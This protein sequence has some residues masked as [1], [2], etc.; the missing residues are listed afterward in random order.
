MVV[1]VL[2]VF[3]ITSF[4]RGLFSG[5]SGKG[6]STY[7]TYA[8]TSSYHSANDTSSGAPRGSLM[9]ITAKNCANIRK[10]PSSKT[11][12]VTTAKPGK[13]FTATGRTERAANGGLWYEICLDDGSKAWASEQ[14]I[15]V[16]N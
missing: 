3:L 11:D 2:I 9:V 7:T 1:G 12:I 4:V 8:A 5:S 10:G 13:T 14:V 16:K 6:S 15:K